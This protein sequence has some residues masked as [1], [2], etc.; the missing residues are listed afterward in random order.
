MSLWSSF[1]TNEARVIQKWKHYFPV[2][3]RHFA[4]F[5]NSDVVFVEIGCGEGGSLQMWKRFLGPH[6]RIIGLDINP[7]CEAVAED[8]IE[9]R[10][11]DQSDAGFL[12][13]IVD[14]FGAPDI[15]LDDG[16]HIMSDVQAAFAALY[17]KLTRNGV[18]F[19][20]DLHTA[21]WIE[22]EG[23]LKRSG[24]FIESCKDL[25]DELN[26]EH[27]RGA[28]EPTDF[29]RFTLSMHFY[30][31]IV[32]FEKGRHTRKHAPRIGRP[33]QPVRD[34]SST[35]PDLR[36]PGSKMSPTVD[37]AGGLYLDLLAKVVLNQ[38]YEDPSQHPAHD[39]KFVPEYRLNGHDWPLVGH[40]M[41]GAKR[42]ANLRHAVETV[43]REGVPGDFIETGVWRGGACIFMRGALKAY[44]VTDRKVYVADSFQGLP[45]PDPERFPSDKDDAHHTFAAL[46]VS[47]GEVERNFQTYDLLDRQV[48]FIEG[49][50][51]ETLPGRDFGPLA[52]VRL[53][54]DMYSSTIVALESLYPQLAPGGFLIVDDY[55]ALANCRQAVDDYRAMH[56]ITETMHQVDWTGVYWR[57]AGDLR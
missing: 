27:A 14:E 40:S 52:I 24:S 22:Y 3:E 19:V 50:F 44:G 54:G 39:G 12:G 45:E 9:I 47:R 7:V 23:G 8:Q 28:L 35:P 25:I 30:D 15:V 13:A 29:T 5:V 43:L 55:G 37:A 49:F 32:V 42:I 53:D 51:D 41:I 21:Y 6:A 18:Y 2:Y 33:V 57:K 34:A 46:A 20:E 56:G 48:E 11:G 38:I 31:S 26:A 17:P 1:L 36:P 10:I 4:R 16:S